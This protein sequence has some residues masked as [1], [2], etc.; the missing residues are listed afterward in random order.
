MNHTEIF[1][2]V[3]FIVFVSL[4]C[5]N[6]VQLLLLI[7]TMFYQKIMR[8]TIGPSFNITV[9]LQ[10]CQRHM[11]TIYTQVYISHISVMPKYSKN[12][13]TKNTDK[14]INHENKIRFINC[15]RMLCLDLCAFSM[16]SFNHMIKKYP[17]VACDKPFHLII[18]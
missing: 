9:I 13:L 4:K 8:F 6:M 10:Y 11:S 15:I 3:C 1:E 12:Y 2:F 17:R 7:S 18:P 14:N 5:C 16:A